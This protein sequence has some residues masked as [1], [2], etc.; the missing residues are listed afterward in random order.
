MSSQQELIL[1]SISLSGCQRGGLGDEGDDQVEALT[2]IDLLQRYLSILWQALLSFTA[3]H[4][5]LWLLRRCHRRMMLGIHHVRHSIESKQPR[6]AGGWRTRDARPV[7][8]GDR[9]TSDACKPEVKMGDRLRDRGD[10]IETRDVDEAVAAQRGRGK[11][12]TKRRPSCS[13]EIGEG[14]LLEG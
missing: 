11:G 4:E 3:Q 8:G 2:I 12:R 7:D 10:Q 6:T 14:C 9:N 5:G 1:K 13:S